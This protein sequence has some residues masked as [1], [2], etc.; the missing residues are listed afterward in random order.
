[1]FKNM[2]IEINED[3]SIDE[4]VV[5]LEKRGYVLISSDL[6][7]EEFIITTHK[8]YYWIVS[9]IKT[10]ADFFKTT[11]LQQLKEIQCKI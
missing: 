6:D 4:I 9:D 7:M 11:T 1:M 8:G 5:E 2:K 3:Q 10:N